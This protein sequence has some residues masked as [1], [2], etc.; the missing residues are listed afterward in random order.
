M[1]DTSGHE[2]P[3]IEAL[4][5][6]GRFTVERAHIPD[7][8][9]VFLA[10]PCLRP[11][12]PDGAS[13]RIIVQSGLRNGAWTPEFVARNAIIWLRN[14]ERQQLFYSQP[15]ENQSH[16]Q[17]RYDAVAAALRDLMQQYPSLAEEDFS[18]LT[19]CSDA[20]PNAWAK[21]SPHERARRS[22]WNWDEG[23]YYA[24]EAGRL[25]KRMLGERLA[26]VGAFDVHALRLLWPDGRE[27][28]ASQQ[29]IPWYEFVLCAEEPLRLLCTG[30]WVGAPGTVSL[31]PDKMVEDIG[32]WLGAMCL[33]SANDVE[34]AARFADEE[35]RAHILEGV[36]WR[37][38]QHDAIWPAWKEARAAHPGPQIIYHDDPDT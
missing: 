17:W 1:G 16:E 20:D 7:A 3:K 34:Y 13:E 24:W 29:G 25:A 9:E 22:W 18:F 5:R 15:S 4:A 38:A 21:L 27:E 6:Y 10:S 23:G 19:A 33:D 11:A 8:P 28:P 35:M 2:L 12:R 36:D 26:Q 14:W 32:I 30:W 37:Q 31:E